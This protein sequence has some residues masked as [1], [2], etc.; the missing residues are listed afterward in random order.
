MSHLLPSLG[1]D[2]RALVIGG[3]GTIGSA[4]IAH[5]TQDSGCAG[6]TGL[7]RADGMDLLDEASIAHQAERLA[8]QGFELIIDATG[9]LTID[10][11]GPEKSLRA[12]DPVIMARQF[13]INAIG[14]AL[15]LKHF[16]PRLPLT[17]KSVFASL[18]A[19]VGSIG[20]NALGGW[21]SYRASKAA[22]NQIIKTA[23][24]E[25]ARTRPQAVIVALHPGTVQSPLS[26]PYVGQRTTLSPEDSAA[27][28]LKV[29]EGLSP[30]HSGGFFAY[31]GATLPW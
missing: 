17:G 3:T 23:S 12:L 18:S 27:R 26:Q 9:I 15:L 28:L 1:Q 2:Y 22:L 31:D 19:K 16:S 11:T 20:D 14:P 29:L 4:F 10:G 6:V 5:L 8:G 21:I 13:A 30:K 25:L 24:I 7:S